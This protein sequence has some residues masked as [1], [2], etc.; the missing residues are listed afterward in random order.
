MIRARLHILQ[1][2]IN[3]DQRSR[4]GTRSLRACRSF[5]TKRRE[6]KEVYYGPRPSDS[7][8]GRGRV[9]RLRGAVRVHCLSSHWQSIASA[10]FKRPEKS[11]DIRALWRRPRA[12][13]KAV[14]RLYTR[15][16]RIPAEQVFRELSSTSLF[17]AANF[18]SCLLSMLC[19]IRRRVRSTKAI[20]SARQLSNRTPTPKCPLTSAIAI[21][22]VYLGDFGQDKEGSSLRSLDFREFAL[23]VRRT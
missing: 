7:S 23:G 9:A 19:R 15:P 10:A 11:L 16:N 1:F 13:A 18:R 8:C 14:R 22:A 6:A 4:D 5:T 21:K 20:F 17:Q 2:V 12:L 3:C